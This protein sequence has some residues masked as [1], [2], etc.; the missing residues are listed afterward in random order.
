MRRTTRDISSQ[1]TPVEKHLLSKVT[2]GRLRGVCW[3]KRDDLAAATDGYY[4]S[5]SKVRQYAAM[6]AKAPG[7]DM[8]VGCS[9]DSAM[10]IYVAAAA[11]RATC[12]G[13][14]TKAHVY[15]PARKKRT[16]ATDYATAMGATIVEVRPGYLSVVKAEARKHVDDLLANGVQVVRWNADEAVRDA[17]AQCSN[18]PS[19]VRRIVIPTGSGLTAAGV[20]AGLAGH[21]IDVLAVCVSDMAQRADII[22]LAK[23]FATG[24][25]PSF[26]MVRTKSKYTEPV[27]ARLPDNTILDPYY[28]AKAL[29]YLKEGD[30]LWLPGVRP[31]QAIPAKCRDELL[32]I[33]PLKD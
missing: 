21:N 14:P 11:H 28:A 26:R 18:I 33:L 19:S 13:I 31:M 12:A 32:K 7:A 29:P 4:P 2:G 22:K 10:Q 15:V 6:A 24:K 9:A 3:I 5:G 25:L 30:C 17:A 27:A 16:Q 1:L 20:L 23:R 8:V